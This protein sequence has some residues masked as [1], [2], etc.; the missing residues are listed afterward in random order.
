MKPIHSIFLSTKSRTNSSDNQG[1][2]WVPMDIALN[3]GTPGDSCYVMLVS[4]SPILMASPTDIVVCSSSIR[5]PY[6]WDSNMVGESTGLGHLV[7][8]LATADG[9]YHSASSHDNPAVP[10][11]LPKSGSIHLRLMNSLTMEPI[12]DQEYAIHLMVFQE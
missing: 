5:Q 8:L 1:D 10:C 6:S 9:V 4:S 12:L 2:C 7:P 3:G 11:V